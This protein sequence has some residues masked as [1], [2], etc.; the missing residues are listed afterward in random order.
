MRLISALLC[1]FI[2][3]TFCGCL[4]KVLT[5]ATHSDPPSQAD[6]DGIIASADAFEDT[7]P[8][9]DSLGITEKSLSNHYYHQLTA[10]E[11]LLY[12]ANLDSWTNESP[13]LTVKNIDYYLYCIK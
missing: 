13:S 6:P 7:L 4:D 11:Q 3:L 8:T 10:E 1:I 12:V 5:G 9:P 2:L